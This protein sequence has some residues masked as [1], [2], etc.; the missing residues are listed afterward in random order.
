MSYMERYNIEVVLVNVTYANIKRHLLTRVLQK[1][2]WYVEIMRVKETK[3]F[4]DLLGREKK[5]IQ[6]EE[7]VKAN[8]VI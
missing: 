1:E 3:N 4:N 7:I 8:K 2:T 5:Y 6:Y